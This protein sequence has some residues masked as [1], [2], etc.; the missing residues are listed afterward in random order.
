M[1]A[2]TIEFKGIYSELFK[3][4]LNQGTVYPFPKLNPVNVRSN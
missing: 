4:N 2:Y 1:G 3:L